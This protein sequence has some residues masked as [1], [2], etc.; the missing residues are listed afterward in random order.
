VERELGKMVAGGAA[1]G[2]DGAVGIVR[3]PGREHRNV[4][5]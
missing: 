2:V 4:T 5:E 3:V 1:A